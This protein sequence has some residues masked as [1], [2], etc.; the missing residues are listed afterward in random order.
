MENVRVLAAINKNTVSE[1]NLKILS[2]KYNLSDE[3]MQELNQY[4]KD[5]GIIVYDEEEMACLLDYRR[6]AQS[7]RK[8]SQIDVEREREKN[9]QTSIIAKRIMRVAYVSA[10]KR[11]NNNGW[12]CGTYMR[13]VWRLVQRQVK[14]AFSGEEMKYIIDHLNDF[15]EE[16]FF[17]MEDQ[18][19][20]ERC[21]V[22]NKKLNE[23]I[24]RLQIKR[25]YSDIFDEV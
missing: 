11:A 8:P 23:L 21:D 5:N 24:P 19:S 25:F 17:A 15:D 12:L 10:R 2:V 16:D 4:C 7:V 3:E 6:I 14:R 22:L 9:R 18:Q 13:S 1:Q 20:P